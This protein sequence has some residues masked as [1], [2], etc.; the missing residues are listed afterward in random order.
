[1][2]KG[3]PFQPQRFAQYHSPANY[4][5]SDDSESS[6]PVSFPPPLRPNPAT[7]SRHHASSLPDISSSSSLRLLPATYDDIPEIVDIHIEAYRNDVMVRLEYGDTPIDDIKKAMIANLQEQWSKWDG[8]GLWAIKAVLNGEA[9][10][11]AIWGVKDGKHEK[12]MQDETNVLSGR[13]E[14]RRHLELRQAFGP[15]QSRNW[16]QWRKTSTSNKPR[17]NAANNLRDTAH[18][19][20]MQ[21]HAKWVNEDTRFLCEFS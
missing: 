1:M 19:K 8:Q 4:H 21:L 17:I 16:S 13:R 11:C 18:A 6:D 3:L 7:V 12:E 9:V 5:P 10:G 2:T 20:L 14:A 15:P